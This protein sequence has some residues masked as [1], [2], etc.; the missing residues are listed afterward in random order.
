MKVEDWGGGVK[1]W[2]LRV[3]VGLGLGLGVGIG[4]RLGAKSGV[5]VG[6]EG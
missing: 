2:R 3:E 6:V 1:G 4:V 5:W